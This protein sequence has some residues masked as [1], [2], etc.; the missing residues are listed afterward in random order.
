MAW[1]ARFRRKKPDIS[2]I[3]QWRECIDQSIDQVSVLVPPPQQD[4]VDHILIL[5]VD[6]L[7]AVYPAD[8][9]AKLLIAVIVITDL[10]HH[11][12]R[13]NTEPL[14]LAAFVLRLARGR[15]H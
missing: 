7:N 3:G 6:Q 4:N 5:F 11:L 14:G 9:L 1:P 10:L 15:A 13:L 2:P 12:A 8:R